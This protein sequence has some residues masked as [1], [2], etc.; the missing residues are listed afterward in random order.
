LRTRSGSVACN[1]VHRLEE[2][3]CRWLMQTR[4]LIETLP[5]TQ[6]IPGANARVQ[7]SSVT[8][9]ASG[10]AG[11]GLITYR[12]GTIQC[13]TWTPCETRLANVTPPSTPISSASSAGA[14]ISSLARRAFIPRRPTDRHG[15]RRECAPLLRCDA[16]L[17]A[18]PGPACLAAPTPPR[19]LAPS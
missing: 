19:F 9:I 18:R 6:G 5:L 4:D 12:R 17:L 7:R 3:L 1:A 13:L 16:V 15:L 10:A 2:R 11:A 8:L 14:P